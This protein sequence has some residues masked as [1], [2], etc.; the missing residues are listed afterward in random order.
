MR[1]L[2]I[3]L[4][5]IVINLSVSAQTA[6]SLYNEGVKLKDEKKSGQ[7]LLKFKQAT[8]L[9]PNYTDALYE[10]GWCSNDT[11]DYYGAIKALRQVMPAMSDVYKANFELGYAFEKTESYD[12]ATYYYT[13]C[14]SINSN[15]AGVHKQLGY[16]AYQ[17]EDYARALEYFINYEKNLKTPTTDYLYWYRKGF[18]QN[19]LKDYTASKSSLTKSLE[20]KTDYLNT[21]LELGF[22]CKNLKESDNAIEWYKKAIA[23]DPK[24]HIPY[25][26]IGEVYRDNIKDMD[27]AMEWY[28]KTLDINPKER[29]GNFGMGYCL[30]NLQKY[31]E[32]VPYLKTAIQMENTYTAAYTELGFS[33]YKLGNYSDALTNLNKSLSQNPNGINPL[34]YATLVYLAQKNKAKAQEMVNTLKRIGSKYGDDLQKNVDAL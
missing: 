14:L 21:Y 23:V 28:Q 31:S 17:K 19:A 8:E 27:K 7:A 1:P 6:E 2:K 18:M 16:I 20:F 13:R 32:A 30:N 33:Y 34:Y 10:L 11:K 24:S 26:G 12:S 15:N 22:A 25:N 9:K 5:L 29:K 4:P 3:L